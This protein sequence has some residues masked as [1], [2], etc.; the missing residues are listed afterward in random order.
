MFL[1]P[2]VFGIP[3]YFQNPSAAYV[4]NSNGY[5]LNLNHSNKIF[6]THIKLSSILQYNGINVQNKLQ[7][8]QDIDSASLSI[9]LS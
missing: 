1:N 3:F 2:F 9:F 5:Y 7:I 8:S 6:T 4:L